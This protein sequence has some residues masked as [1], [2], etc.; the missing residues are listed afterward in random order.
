MK[1][2]YCS[3]L[4]IVMAALLTGIYTVP[5]C[6]G[7]REGIV[8]ESSLWA[9]ALNETYEEMGKALIEEI[10]SRQPGNNRDLQT[11]LTFASVEEA[12]MFGLYFYRYG[13]LGKE[14]IV[15]KVGNVSGKHTVFVNSSDFDSALQEHDTVIRI[16]ETVVNE[17]EGKND[18]E[19]AHAF[20][21]WLYE[22]VSYDYSMGKK[23]VYDA[24]I[25]G[26]SVCWGF[27]GTF[28]KLCR[29][30][31]LN[32]EAVYEGEHVWNRVM[33]QGEW[34]HCD[35]TWD[36]CGGNHQWCF[37]SEKDMRA[38]PLHFKGESLCGRMGNS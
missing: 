5:A 31:G 22:R 21:D 7:E 24:V 9:E 32:C 25:N 13:Y 35:I 14:K 12:K 2:R 36:K 3:F 11:G 19:K 6:G 29:M 37:V 4:A 28:L 17:A 23:T 15:L 16:L 1:K 38:D 8:G 27:T 26:K 34:K 30:A 20:Y 18:E 10:R 33:I